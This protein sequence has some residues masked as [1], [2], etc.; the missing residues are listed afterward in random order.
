MRGELTGEKAEEVIL[1][2]DEAVREALDDCDKRYYDN[3]EAIADM[4]FAWIKAN[5]ALVRVGDAS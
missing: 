4:L 5:R 2:D 3:D 1:A